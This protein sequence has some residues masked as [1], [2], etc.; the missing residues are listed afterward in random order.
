MK[1]FDPE[2]RWQRCGDDDCRTLGHCHSVWPI[3]AAQ[4]KSRHKHERKIIC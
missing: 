2:P 3:E 1:S 4:T